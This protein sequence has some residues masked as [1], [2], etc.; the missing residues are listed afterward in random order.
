MRRFYRRYLE[1]RRVGF[2]R[3]DAIR[4][5]WATFRPALLRATFRR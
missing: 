3:I 4:F 2:N 5:A 1:Y